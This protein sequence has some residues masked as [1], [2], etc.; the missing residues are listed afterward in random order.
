MATRYLPA[1][2]NFI[3]DLRAAFRDAGGNKQ[4]AMERARDHL[5]NLLE[6]EALFR[7]SRKWPS[8]EGHKNLLLYEDRD[9][10]FV[11]NAV[12]RTLDRKR[13]IHDH[14]GAWTAYGILDGEEQL[15]RYS[16]LDDGTREGFA[17]IRL[18]ST[19]NGERGTVDLVPPFGIHSESGGANR[20]VAIIVRS[21]RLVGKVLQGRYRPD[22]NSTFQGEGPIQVP[23]EVSDHSVP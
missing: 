3:D 22:T 19:T 21:E 13:G 5:A 17:E 18:E 9:Y 8:T 12:V 2:Q 16:R 10:G 14:A 6:D 20:S 1:F 15:S 7:H 11:V 23:F 4:V